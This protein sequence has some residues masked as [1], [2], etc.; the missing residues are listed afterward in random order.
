MKKSTRSI[1][2]GEKGEDDDTARRRK[3]FIQKINN[4]L[5]RSLRMSI[6]Q[7]KAF[8]SFEE[9]LHHSTLFR[10]L[11]LIYHEAFR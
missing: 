4:G 10:K 5:E 7:L 11:E 8:L 1:E 3:S 6:D 9:K 2:K